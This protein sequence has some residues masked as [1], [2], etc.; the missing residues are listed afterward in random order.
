MK[1]AKTSLRKKLEAERTFHYQGKNQ[2]PGQK[3][4]DPGLV[5]KDQG[6]NGKKTT[7]QDSKV[8]ERN[9]T[10]GLQKSKLEDTKQNWS[11]LFY[12][13]K[14]IVVNK[15][16]HIPCDLTETMEEKSVGASMTKTTQT[17]ASTV[18]YNQ[19]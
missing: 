19:N 11:V 17:Q 2:D 6:K 5:R 1:S 18:K 12:E 3:L 14:N 9:H 7:T 13:D 16:G 10:P 15:Y 4:G 8:W